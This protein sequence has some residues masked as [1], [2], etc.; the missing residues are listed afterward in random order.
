MEPGSVRELTDRSVDADDVRGVYLEGAVQAESDKDD[1][2]VRAP[3]MYYDFQTDRAIML[4]AVLRTYDRKRN[5]P[6]YARAK[7]LRQVA[8][9]QWTGKQVAVSASSFATP[10][11]IGSRSVVVN[12]EP[13]GA[14]KSNGWSK[15]SSPSTARAPH[16]KRADSRCS[17][18]P[19][20]S[21]PVHTIPLRGGS[22]RLG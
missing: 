13:G 12:R 15:A 18:G 21:G 16:W 11:A 3:R 14:M 2:V 22:R 4:D 6:V 19:G 5:L 8:E 20:T 7:E 1:Y 9:E 10:L 17:G